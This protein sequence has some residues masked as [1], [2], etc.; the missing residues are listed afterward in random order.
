MQHEVVLKL[1][2]FILV[3]WRSKEGPPHPKAPSMMV[4]FWSFSEIC[5]KN[6]HS[7]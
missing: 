7:K 4:L 1:L 6:G 3:Q 2:T 5:A